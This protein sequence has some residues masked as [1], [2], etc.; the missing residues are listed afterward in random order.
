MRSRLSLTHLVLGI[1]LTLALIIPIAALR[2]GPS[3]AT[4]RSSRPSVVVDPPS[5]AIADVG[6]HDLT[7]LRRLTDAIAAYA[8][9]VTVAR[10][11]T[12]AVAV[13]DHQVRAYL[14]HEWR[15]AH[16]PVV[17][18]ARSRWSGSSGSSGSSS[19]SAGLTGNCYGA[20]VHGSTG[21]A[22]PSYICTRESGYTINVKNRSSSASG[23]YQF[24]D[25]TW[26]GYGGYQHAGQAP[27]ALQDA[28]ARQV[29][30]STGGGAWRCC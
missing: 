12:Y 24:L 15:V 14:A 19:S 17:H 28:R 11:I 7:G 30:A 3:A 21:C 2:G 6:P 10:A 18:L 23:K 4:A 1:V 5:S 8:H 29:W 13:H 9:D 25:G 16:P 26:G 27:E 20:C 22:I